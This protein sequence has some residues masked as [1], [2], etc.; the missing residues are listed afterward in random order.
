[1]IAVKNRFRDLMPSLLPSSIIQLP[2]PS[3]LNLSLSLKKIYT[4]MFAN[5]NRF[6]YLR[7]SLLPSSSFQLPAF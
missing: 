2:A 1:M 5:K 3:L 4:P 6:R 7:P